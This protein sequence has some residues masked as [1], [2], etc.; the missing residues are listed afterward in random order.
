MERENIKKYLISNDIHVMDNSF[1]F[2]RDEYSLEGI[3]KQI[4][5][6]NTIHNV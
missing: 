6:I 5:V 4:V 2:N 3:K 1:Y